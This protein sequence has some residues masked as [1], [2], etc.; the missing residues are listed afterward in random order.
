MKKRSFL[1]LL[2]IIFFVV[3]LFLSAEVSGARE[4]GIFFSF[5]AGLITF[6]TAYVLYFGTFFYASK[7]QTALQ[8][9]R[10]R[11]MRDVLM[12]SGLIGAVLGITIMS[13]FAGSG[14]AEALGAGMSASL[15][16]PLYGLLG[17]IGFYFIEKHLDMK[18]DGEQMNSYPVKSGINI[19]SM[20]S[21][22]I[23]IIMFIF[24]I[25][26]LTSAQMAFELFLGL[27]MV[28]FVAAMIIASIYIFDGK[29]VARALRVPF[30]RS[31]VDP[32]PPLKVVRGLKRIV[33][34]IGLVAVSV[35]PIVILATFG[36]EI[37]DMFIPLGK[38][39]VVLFWSM[40]ILLFLYL[41]EG[42]L[43]QQGYYKTGEIHYDDRFFVVKFIVPPFLILFF[44]MWLV[45]LFYIFT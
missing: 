2:G 41:A 45:F 43:V 6:G 35:T 28:Y 10:A 3:L 27:P 26:L 40:F 8:I 14:S 42:Q 19:R 13:T 5:V 24:G 36:E 33:S 7:R 37:M 39:G 29:A 4:M 38:T 16:A 23:L 44:S 25:L 9:F 11:W 31:N 32:F 15:L 34:L 18:K 30:L 12:L 21:L 1:P 17:A 22:V 20:M